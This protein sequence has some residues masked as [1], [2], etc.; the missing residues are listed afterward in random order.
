MS[1]TYTPGK[2][3]ALEA[4]FIELNNKG[5]FKKL[6]EEAEFFERMVVT[7]KRLM[8]TNDVFKANTHRQLN[9]DPLNNANDS[10]SLMVHAGISLEN[11]SSVQ[12]DYYEGVGGEYAPGCEAWHVSDEGKTN[13]AKLLHL[14]DKELTVRL[15][16][17]KVAYLLANEE[18]Y[19]NE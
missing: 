15:A 9:W 12:Y 16:I 10:F 4:A 1:I 2:H 13:K 11:N 18:N 5:H 8:M 17:L 6:K 19:D 7:T 3:P 14:D